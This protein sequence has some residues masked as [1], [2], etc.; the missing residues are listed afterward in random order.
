MKKFLLTISAF[1]TFVGMSAQATYNYFD[2]ADVDADGWLWFDTQAKIDKYVG[3]PGMG[4]NPK[5][6]LYTATWADK[7]GEYAEPE[8]NPTVAGWNAAGELGG[9]GAKTGAIMLPTSDPEVSDIINDDPKGGG[10]MLWLP[11]CAEFDLFVST[12]NNVIIPAVKGAKGWQPDVDCGVICI[13]T[14]RKLF[15]RG[16]PLAET[17]QYEW[18]NIQSLSNTGLN[19][20]I[21]SKEKVTG[22][23][24]NNMK[25][26][27]YIHGIKVLTYTKSSDSSAGI[28][29]VVDGS[30]FQLS[31]NGK[32]VYATENAAISVYSVAG[33]KVAEVNGASVSLENL[34]PGAYVVKAV[35][36]N[37]AATIKVVR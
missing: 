2:A 28:D 25:H 4:A 23:V 34:A 19:L 22:L 29:D 36:G 6:M 27:L 30:V 18:K 11:D 31:F 1:A 9:A 8:C 15:G 7:N 24:R 37:G 26:P 33:S 12:S 21:A 14:A 35:S 17:S 3:F 20:S 10:I 13:Y 5:I 16:G 32:E